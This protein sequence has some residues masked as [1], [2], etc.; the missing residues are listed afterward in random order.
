M[1]T[2]LDLAVRANPRRRRRQS[3]RSTPWLR[4]ARANLLIS[5]FIVCPAITAVRLSLTIV[6]AQPPARPPSQGRHRIPGMEMNP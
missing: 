1:S 4:P 6:G 3:G 5:P 2:D